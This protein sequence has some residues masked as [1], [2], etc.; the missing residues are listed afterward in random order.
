MYHYHILTQDD[1]KNYKDNVQQT[2][3]FSHKRRLVQNAG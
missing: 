3:S 2:E 1:N